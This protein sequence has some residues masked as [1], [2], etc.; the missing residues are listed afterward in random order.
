M[1]IKELLDKYAPARHLQVFL[2]QRKVIR[3]TIRRRFYDDGWMVDVGP[4]QEDGS[5]LVAATDPGGE[6]HDLLVDGEGVIVKENIW[7][8]EWGPSRCDECGGYYSMDTRYVSSCDDCGKL[9]FD[10]HHCLILDNELHRIYE[11]NDLISFFHW[12]R[13]DLEVWG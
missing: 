13:V 11:G 4:V 5:I 6:T 3:D 9:A 7:G 10:E 1:K 12:E 2:N 8:G